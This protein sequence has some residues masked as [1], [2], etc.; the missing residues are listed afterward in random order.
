MNQALQTTISQAGVVPVIALERVDQALPLADALLA[1]G[2]PVIEVTFRTAAAAEAIALLRRERPRLCV[3]AGTV[4]TPEEVTAAVQA[5]SQFAVAPGTNPRILAQ[6]QAQ[7]LPF[8]PG[9]CTPSDVE[10]ALEA[11]CTDLKFFPASAAGG[12]PMLKS[13]YAPYRHRG[14]RFMPT[15]GV[16]PDN[17]GEWLQA[18]GVFVVGGTWIAPSD[19]LAAGDFQGISKRA[20]QASHLVQE[21]RA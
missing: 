5:G 12:I 18:P 14:I 6:A 13:L 4:T 17:L 16:K 2:L 1:G 11:G 3:G 15:G 8:L 20:Q 21:I 19:L 9:V 7:G 10:A